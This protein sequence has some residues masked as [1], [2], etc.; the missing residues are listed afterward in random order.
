MSEVVVRG[1]SVTGGELV[2]EVL[3]SDS[4][5]GT[6]EIAVGDGGVSRLDGP[7]WLAQ[8]AHRRRRVEHDLGAVQAEHE[9]VQWVVAAVAD[10]HGHSTVLGLREAVVSH[11]IIR[12]RGTKTLLLQTV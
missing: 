5:D 3:H 12:T 1:P 11:R 7:E 8:R 9:P 2:G 4:V 6:R 10:V